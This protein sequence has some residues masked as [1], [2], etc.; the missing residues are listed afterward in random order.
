MS[1]L[2]ILDRDDRVPQKWQIQFGRGET[3]AS[4]DA[5][6]QLSAEM[7]RVLHRRYDFDP[8]PPSRMEIHQSNEEV[9][10]ILG[11]IHKAK[12]RLGH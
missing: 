9:N 3:E 5:L 2:C 6:D 4:E 11:E 12:M 8:I 1:T 10:R 7:D